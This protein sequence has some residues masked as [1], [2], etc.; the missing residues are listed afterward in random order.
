MW[1]YRVLFPNLYFTKYPSDTPNRHP[2]HRKNANKSQ[3]IQKEH[4]R[5]KW[6]PGFL[7]PSPFRPKLGKLSYAS[8][9]F[10]FGPSEANFKTVSW[11]TLDSNSYHRPVNLYHQITFCMICS[12][13]GASHCNQT[14]QPIIAFHAWFE[15]AKIV[16]GLL[17]LYGR[18]MRYLGIFQ[19]FV[20]I[21]LSTSLK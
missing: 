6:D 13:Y 12:V 8:Y 19:D 17:K 20:L 2:H 1:I 4:S 16:L 21:A 15:I 18:K 14:N 7:D 9:L 10:F 3:Q 11:I 5:K